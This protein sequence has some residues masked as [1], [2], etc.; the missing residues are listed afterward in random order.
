[1]DIK[2]IAAKYEPW[3]I[4]MRRHFHA[5]PE[6]SRQEEATARRVREELTRLGVEWQPCGAGYGTLATIRGGKPGKTIL[7]RADMDALE[8][9]E[10]TG[11]EYASRTPGVMHA[12]GHDCHTAMLLGAAAILC[13]MKSELPGTVRLAFQPAE[14]V[15]E[16]ACDMIAHGAIEGVDACFAIHVWA[17]VDSGK[18]AVP[19]GPRMAA[20]DQFRIE[21]TGRGSHGA[22][23]HQGVDA[24][25]AVC[26]M[27][28]ALQTVVSREIDPLQS[29][30]LTVGMV[31]A[32]TR[33]NVVSE[34]GFLEGTTRSFS[35]EV[36]QQL[37]DAIF[38]IMQHTAAAN[39]VEAELLWNP[40]IIGVP[41]LANDPG[42][43]AAAE[44]A[45]RL[46]MG[47]DAP[48]WTEKTG[49]AEDFAF[50]LEKAP[51]A[52]ALLGIRNP[53][54]GAVHPHHSGR[55]CVDESALIRGAMLYAQTAVEVNGT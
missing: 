41:P 23:P 39:R 11:A 9:Q 3:V 53:E 17:D 27:A 50:F 24:V 38:R 30:V 29:A 5:N 20:A 32:G 12:C 13:E 18:V 49:G 7:L 55:F 35:P 22:A 44:R 54:C 43:S 31:G 37:Q 36:R 34:R 19:A 46:V 33:F 42:V 1:M 14:E 51:G 48:I 2:E 8:V 52:L 6:P 28:N 26:S 45:A 47:E 4:D 21:I 15:G 25:V 40:T 16:G 10:D